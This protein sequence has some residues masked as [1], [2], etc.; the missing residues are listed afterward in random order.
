MTR[1]RGRGRRGCV[2]AVEVRDSSVVGIS[3][4]GVNM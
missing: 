4:V 1:G 2:G 3:S